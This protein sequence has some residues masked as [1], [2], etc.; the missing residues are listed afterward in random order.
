MKTI[1][2]IFC[3]EPHLYIMLI[4]HEPCLIP[5]PQ[6]LSNDTSHAWFD[7]EPKQ[8]QSLWKFLLLPYDAPLPYVLVDFSY[9]IKPTPSL[10][11]SNT[12]RDHLLS[13]TRIQFHRSVENS[14]HMYIVIKLS[15]LFDCSASDPRNFGVWL[16]A[17]QRHWCIHS[18]IW[19]LLVIV[20]NQPL[21]YFCH[22]I[23]YH[24]LKHWSINHHLW[25]FITLPT[26]PF[27]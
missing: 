1:Q 14:I 17:I 6:S 25:N 16:W 19:W 5:T 15:C 4:K 10:Y 26:F 9:Y 20:A 21:K 8:P 24:S 7:K 11:D 3:N 12:H 13:T 22:L 18:C 27:Y 2:K 23:V